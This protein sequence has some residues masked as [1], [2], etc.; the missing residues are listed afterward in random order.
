MSHAKGDYV[1]GRWNAAD[2]MRP[3]FG[4]LADAMLNMM[5]R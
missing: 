3:P 1:Q 2:L 4:R 5:L